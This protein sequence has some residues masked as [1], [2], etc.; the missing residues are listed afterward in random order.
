MQSQ[1]YMKQWLDCHSS[2]SLFLLCS[3]N[4]N[5]DHHLFWLHLPSNAVA[6]PLLYLFI[7]WFWSHYLT[8]IFSPQ[9]LTSAYNGFDFDFGVLFQPLGWLLLSSTSWVAPQS[10]FM[11][12]KLF[13]CVPLCMRRNKNNFVPIQIWY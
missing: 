3:I 11:G 4:I 10:Q 12:F 7:C 6:T 1:T 5:F 8:I 2:L 13:H 9:K